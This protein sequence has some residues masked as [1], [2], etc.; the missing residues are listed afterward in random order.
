MLIKPKE[1]EIK[2]NVGGEE[3]IYTYRIGRYNG[4]DGLE[5]VEYATDIVK[6]GLNFNGTT[7]GLLKECLIKMGR[8]IEAV[9]KSDTEDDRYILLDNATVLGAYLPDAETSMQLMKELHDYNS[10]F[11]NTENLS[12]Q[13]ASWMDRIEE[14]IVETLERSPLFSS[15]EDTQRSESLEN[16]TM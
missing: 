4:L 12:I 5:F 7:K 2:S 1:I 3:E 16:T 10:F 13:S 8:F 11:L 15:Q 9:I 14:L 6:S